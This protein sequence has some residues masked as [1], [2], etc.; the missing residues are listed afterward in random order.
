MTATIWKYELRITDGAQSIEMPGHARVLSAA[1]QDSALVLWALVTPGSNPKSVRRFVVH[2][3]GHP[4]PHQASMRYV[5]VSTVQ[6]GP[7]VWH[8]FEWV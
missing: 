1:M 8:V 7:L 4:I 3:T 6:D 5:P 2:G